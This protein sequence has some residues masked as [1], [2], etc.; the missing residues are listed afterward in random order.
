MKMENTLFDFLIQSNSYIFKFS[1]NLI[2][3]ILR[4]HIFTAIIK[5]LMKLRKGFKKRSDFHH[6]GGGGVQ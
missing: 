5:K 3:D 2:F 1:K 6:F 4:F